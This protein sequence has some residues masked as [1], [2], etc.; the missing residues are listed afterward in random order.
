MSK[1]K[2]EN[3]KENLIAS[4]KKAIET[5]KPYFLI[6]DDKDKAGIAIH[7]NHGE[8]VNIIGTSMLKSEDV[9][10]L[11]K[12]SIMAIMIKNLSEK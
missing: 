12:D 7:G 11:L 9:F 5:E 10:G 8:L 6:F 3:L 1:I 2:K 4:V